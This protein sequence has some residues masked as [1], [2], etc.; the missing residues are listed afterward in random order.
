M[1]SCFSGDQ[2]SRVGCFAGS[3]WSKAP[4]FDVLFWKLRSVLFEG[5]KFVEPFAAEHRDLRGS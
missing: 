1:C 5:M 4:R 3:R 2:G